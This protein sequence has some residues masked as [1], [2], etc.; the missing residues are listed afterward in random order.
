[1]FFVYHL[2]HYGFAKTPWLSAA[3]VAE[4]DHL[5]DVAAVEIDPRPAVAVV[6]LDP[7]Q[8]EV[9]EVASPQVA[10]RQ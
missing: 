6:E 2:Q 10:R 7:V 4:G 5:P 9:A 8:I 3:E 1:V